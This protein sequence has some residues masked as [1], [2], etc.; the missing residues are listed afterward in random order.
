MKP[1]LLASALA[2]A[3]ALAIPAHATTYNWNGGVYN[4]GV[5]SPNPLLSPDILNIL[6]AGN[7]FFNGGVSFTNQS[8]TVNWSNGGIS[9]NNSSSVTNDSLWD[10]TSNNAMGG[11]IGTFTNNGTF[12][13]SAG[14]GIT[15]IT[16]SGVGLFTFA[17]NGTIDAQTGTILINGTG[18]SFNAGTVF[19]GA[20]SVEVSNGNFNGGFTSSNLTLVGLTQT[21]TNAALNGT[22]TM[23]SGTLTGSWAVGAGSTLDL[24]SASTKFFN[25]VAFTNNGTVNWNG[26]SV[27]LNSGSN[28]VNNG[29]WDAT[30]DNAMG[31]G[32]GTFTNNGTFRKSAGAGATNLGGTTVVN[33]GLI[34][35]LSGTIGLASG[36]TNNGTLAGTGAFQTFTTLNNAGTV[37]PGVGVGTGTLNLAGNYAQTAAGTLAIQLA[38]SSAWDLFNITGTAALN[39]TLALSCI[40]SCAIATGD[41]FVILDSTGV[42]SGTFSNITL[43]GFLADFDY[44]LDYDTANRLVRLN[45]LFAGTPGGGGGGT[46]PEPTTWAMLI[47]GFGLVGAASRRR[48]TIA[49]A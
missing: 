18:H 13:K 4:S 47:A 11:G 30:G 49:T 7:H 46:I 6:G 27:S 45:V 31:G 29:L 36:W 23:S 14:A 41:S 37:A 17:N 5:T 19:T 32:V 8:G 9:I 20:G 33:N 28:V 12:R 26:G 42:L 44:S 2:S 10:V 40:L 24:T 39:G 15:T 16:S 1:I 35:V 38:S 48:R 43:S 22:A 21:G 25:S 34:E 3:L